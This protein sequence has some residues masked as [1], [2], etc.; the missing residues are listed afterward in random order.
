M[1]DK[2]LWDQYVALEKERDAMS[3]EVKRL[4]ADLEF[5]K[6]EIARLHDDIHELMESAASVANAPRGG[7]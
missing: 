3:A 2:K 6:A 5:A 4:S 7:A 1:S